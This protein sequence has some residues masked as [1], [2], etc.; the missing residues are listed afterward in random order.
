MAET[1]QMP[2]GHKLT[3][4]QMKEGLVRSVADEFRKARNDGYRTG[5]WIK[6]ASEKVVDHLFE[7]DKYFDDMMDIQKKILANQG[8]GEQKKVQVTPISQSQE[9]SKIK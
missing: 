9:A 5:D 7:M 8:Q 2:D 4:E 1:L 3:K 6:Y